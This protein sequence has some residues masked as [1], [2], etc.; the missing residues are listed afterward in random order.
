[1]RGLSV[2]NAHTLGDVRRASRQQ[3][4]GALHLHQAKAAAAVL[5]KPGYVAQFGNADVVL[6]SD[7]DNR[8][9]FARAGVVSVDF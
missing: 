6:A 2:V 9:L 1:M 3:L 5:R 8:L 4:R 7:V